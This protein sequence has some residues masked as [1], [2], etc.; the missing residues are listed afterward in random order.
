MNTNT[1][2][3]NEPVARKILEM[4]KNFFAEPKNQKDFEEWHFKKYGCLPNKN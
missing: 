3:I 4:A 1:I 2:V